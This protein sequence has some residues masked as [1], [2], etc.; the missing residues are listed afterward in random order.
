MIFFVKDI[1]MRLCAKMDKCGLISSLASPLKTNS[2][3][4]ME[5]KTREGKAFEIAG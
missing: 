5:N 4:Y 2:H 1:V 3:I